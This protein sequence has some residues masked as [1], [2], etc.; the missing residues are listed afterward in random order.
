MRVALGVLLALWGAFFALFSRRIARG[1]YPQ[2]RVAAEE[3]PAGGAGPHRYTTA[4]NLV[5]GAAIA[6]CG[7]LVAVSVL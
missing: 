2:G 4:L 1:Q 7:I 5:A 6:V 3:A